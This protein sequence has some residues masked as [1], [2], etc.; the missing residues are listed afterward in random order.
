[1]ARRFADRWPFHTCRDPMELRAIGGLD[2]QS[3]NN[4]LLHVHLEGNTSLSRYPLCR[5]VW[6]VPCTVLSSLITPHDLAPPLNPGTVHRV[7]QLLTIYSPTWLRSCS[8][9]ST[10]SSL[11]CGER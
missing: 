8:T 5:V 1:M 10:C 2:E 3:R 6:L 9:R 4:V 11:W 7:D